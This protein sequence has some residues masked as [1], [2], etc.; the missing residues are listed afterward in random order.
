MGGF[1]QESYHFEMMQGTRKSLI[2]PDLPSFSQSNGD[3]Q[4][5]DQFQE[6]ALRSLFSV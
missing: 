2:N 5:T 1:N 6:L 3:M 4:V